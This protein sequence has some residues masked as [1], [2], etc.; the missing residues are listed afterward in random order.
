[1]SYKTSSK[2]VTGV[3]QAVIRFQP[4]GEDMRCLINCIVTDSVSYDLEYSLN[5]EDWVVLGD[6]A[7]LAVTTDAT[8]VF[9]VSAVRVNVTSGTGSVKLIVLSNGGGA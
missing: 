4:R 5:G 7:G 1:M 6:N 3:G 2:S 9:P 8:L